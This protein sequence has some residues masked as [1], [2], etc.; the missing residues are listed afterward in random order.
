MLIYFEC[1]TFVYTSLPERGCEPP[2]GCW[3]LNSRTLGRTDNPLKP[4][5]QLKAQK[6]C[7]SCEKGGKKNV[8]N[9]EN[10]QTRI[11]TCPIMSSVMEE[12]IIDIISTTA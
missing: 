8:S 11:I 3:E 10:C 4:L 1:S 6:P 9:L 7:F 2:C 12:S 5:S